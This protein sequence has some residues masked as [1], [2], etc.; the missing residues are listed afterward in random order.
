M[1]LRVQLFFILFY[2]RGLQGGVLKVMKNDPF[3]VFLA[4][5][6]IFPQVFGQVKKWLLLELHGMV[7]VLLAVAC[8]MDF[9]LLF[10]RGHQLRVLKMLLF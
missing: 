7:R 9:N 5:R 3:L 6:M 2:N 4:V 10:D 1:Q 8:T